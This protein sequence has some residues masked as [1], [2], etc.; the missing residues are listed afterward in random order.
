MA[1]EMAEE[2]LLSGQKVIP[3]RLLEEGFAFEYPDLAAALD[4]LMS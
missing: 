2:L 1:G 3:E 4:D